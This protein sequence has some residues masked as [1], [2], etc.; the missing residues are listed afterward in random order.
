MKNLPQNELGEIDKMRCI[1]NHKNMSREKLLTA[2]LKS[3]LRDAELYKIKSNN[4][5]IEET[6]KFFNE[7]RNKFSKST[8]K[9]IRKDLH[10]K[11]KGLEN[12][13]EQERRQH[14]EELRIFKSFLKRLQKK[15]IKKNYYK[16]I[17]TKGAF[18]DD[19]VKD[20]SRG[21]KDKN[22]LPED[23]LDI[24][25][26]VLRNMINNQDSWRMENNNANHF[27]FFFR[28]KRI[29]YNAFKK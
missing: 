10:K 9:E 5:E 8:I 15:K 17:K 14:A 28:H 1:K 4:A 12:E 19:Y 16:P 20:Q 13:A 3:E 22:L 2:L 21:E 18:N 27:Y 23:Y 11:E 7:I 25:R 24:I 6:R 26:L 29:S